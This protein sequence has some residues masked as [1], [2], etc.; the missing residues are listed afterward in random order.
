MTAALSE[1]SGN[2][3][4][5]IAILSPYLLRQERQYLCNYSIQSLG[6]LR[7]ETKKNKNY[8]TKLVSEAFLLWNCYNYALRTSGVGGYL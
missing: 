7:L 8:Y 4:K 3:G 1:L 6:N 2:Y 5:V